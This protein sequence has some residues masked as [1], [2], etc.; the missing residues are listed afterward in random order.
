MD[1]NLPHCSSRLCVVVSVTAP[2]LSLSFLSLPFVSEQA[3]QQPHRRLQCSPLLPAPPHRR[4]LPSP[5][6]PRNPTLNLSGIS[7]VR[8]T[9]KEGGEGEVAARRPVAGVAIPSHLGGSGCGTYRPRRH[10][11]PRP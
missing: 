7:A 9:G 5:S 3:P 4:L 1:G 6:S 10:L 8:F 11:V 2:P